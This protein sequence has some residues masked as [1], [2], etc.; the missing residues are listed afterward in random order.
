MNDCAHIYIVL[1][2]WQG[3]LKL[4][5]PGLPQYTR[6]QRSARGSSVS[7][8]NV[9][10]HRDEH[11]SRRRCLKAFK[12]DTARDYRPTVLDR[13][14]LKNPRA[15]HGDLV[16]IA[17]IEM[18][19][20]TRTFATS[21]IWRVGPSGAALQQRGRRHGDDRP[22]VACNYV[23]FVVELTQCIPEQGEPRE[24]GPPLQYFALLRQLQSHLRLCTLR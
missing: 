4:N 2:P 13:N 9:H 17:R 8:A 10:R 14:R 12:I 20:L 6:T 24:R 15:E 3:R 23:F 11:G 19:S 21:S 1:R 18:D 22:H 5:S 7:P 16:E